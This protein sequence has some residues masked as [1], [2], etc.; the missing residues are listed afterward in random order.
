LD[1][2]NGER[3]KRKSNIL[4]IIRE[5]SIVFVIGLLLS[6]IVLVPE[7]WATAIQKFWVSLILVIIAILATIGRGFYEDLRMYLQL[8]ECYAL[9]P[10]VIKTISHS[11]ICK[12]T[13]N[14]DVDVSWNFTI[15]NLSEK[16]IPKMS[17]PVCFDI[18]EK[19]YEKTSLLTMKKVKIGTYEVPDPAE[20]YHRAG[21]ILSPRGT[22]SEEGTL[23]V[24]FT[25]KGIGLRKD[26]EAEVQIDFEV[27]SVF[28]KMLEEEWAGVDIAHPT[29]YFDII[30]YPPE[31][32]QISLLSSTKSPKGVEVL[33]KSSW[34]VDHLETENVNEPKCK[35]NRIEWNVKNPKIGYC[36]LLNFKVAPTK[37][38]QGG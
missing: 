12:L 29:D 18:N 25:E 36:Y 10:R 9:M 38:K 23:T 32:Y 15:K 26:K 30:I 4:R 1:N 7:S 22:L 37:L 13:P 19:K 27:K 17:I 5:S 14:G 6:L 24:P 8:R 31:K 33:E 2:N 20:C 34:I 28:K 35:E 3:G 11:R 21:A 16:T